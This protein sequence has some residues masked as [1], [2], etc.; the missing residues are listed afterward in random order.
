[1]D[2]KRAKSGKFRQQSTGGGNPCGLPLQ[3]TWLRA[4]TCFSASRIGPR[5]AATASLSDFR[6][7]AMLGGQAVALGQAVGLGEPVA[8]WRRGL[9]DGRE[10]QMLELSVDAGSSMGVSVSGGSSPPSGTTTRRSSA[11]TPAKSSKGAV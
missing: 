5:R 3:A 6:A 4:L 11:V 7:R 2:G 8:R 1:M 9:F 10:A